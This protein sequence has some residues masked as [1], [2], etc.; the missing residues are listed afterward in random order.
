[1]TAGPSPAAASG[2]G[3]RRELGLLDATM[4]NAGTII[5]SA[6]FIVPSA[7]AAQLGASGPLLLVW[8]IGA[9]VSLCGALCVAELGAALPR[10]G[11]QYVYLGR[12]FSPVVGFLYGWSAFLLINTGSIAAIAV[13][14]ATYLGFFVPLSPGGIKLVAGVSIVGLTLL[15]CLGL[16]VGAFTQ[17]LL[18]ALKIGALVAIVAFAAVATGGS[19]AHYA[20]VWPEGGAATV[21]VRLGPALVAVLWAYDG[22]IEAT[23]VG[24]EIRDPGRN[25]PRSLVLST[26]L[27]A[28]L[29]VVVN[30]AYLWVLPPARMGQSLLVA[31]DAMQVALGA[32]GAA[33]V[34]AAILVS[35][36]GANNGI[37]F[38]SA[39]IPYAMGQEGLFFA[40]A[41]RLHPRFRAPVAVLLVQM[42]V[43]LG[44]TVTGSY[45]QLATYVVFVSFLF[46]A[47]SAAAVIRLRQT[48][49]ALPRPYRAW[50]YP[51]TPIVFILF[52][53]YLVA[54][55]I[56]QTPRDSALG[57]AFVL[58]GLP[59]YWYW[60]RHGAAA[61]APTE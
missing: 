46:Y 61:P 41:T 51:V 44:L 10:A 38:T 1:V 15:N 30:A 32:G 60:R 13:G 26:L 29:Y 35:T 17:N 50:G 19:G 48:E 40:W 37:V 8:V 27:V 54:D 11:G 31:S 16:R 24:S 45:V 55:T 34:A 2:A 47:L 52:A 14:F 25:I 49:P 6:I 39:R 21:A 58:A 42:A 23:Y 53:I 18:T 12:A 59:A 4:I 20:P 56:V 5:A 36:L 28:A 7:L 22:W 9:A 33:F 3:L 57:A 43:A